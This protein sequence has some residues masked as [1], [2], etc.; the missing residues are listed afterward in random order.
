MTNYG[1]TM[2]FTA[3]HGSREARSELCELRRGVER[4]EETLSYI[5]RQLHSQHDKVTREL[6]GLHRLI[7]NLEQPELPMH[8]GG[9][10]R[11]EGALGPPPPH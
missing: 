5:G 11:R 2:K 3:P 7:E 6:Q 4:C 1:H 8:G 9:V 10:G